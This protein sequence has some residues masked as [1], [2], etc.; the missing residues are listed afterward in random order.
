MDVTSALF[1]LAL[2]PSVACCI[3][4]VSRLVP[5]LFMSWT[6]ALLNA[7]RSITMNGTRIYSNTP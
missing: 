5:H 6:G 1:P 2:K 4:L 3:E 7:V